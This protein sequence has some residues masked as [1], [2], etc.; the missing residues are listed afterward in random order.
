MIERRLRVCAMGSIV[1]PPGP[2]QTEWSRDPEDPEA[3]AFREH[4]ADL[5]CYDHC[6]TSHYDW[7][8][9][10]THLIVEER[11]LPPPSLGR[12]LLERVLEGWARGVP[13]R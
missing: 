1:G 11:E 9:H 6:P 3:V 4:H 2:Q 12:W 5:R 10:T 7:D 13:L 8:M